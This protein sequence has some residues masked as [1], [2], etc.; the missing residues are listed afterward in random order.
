MCTPIIATYFSSCQQLPGEEYPYVEQP[1]QEYICPVTY[2]IMLQPHLTECCGHH[3]SQEAALRIQEDNK[4]CPICAQN[5]L[6]VILDK[7]VQR[8]VRGLRVFC[9]KVLKGCTWQGE[10]SDYEYHIQS[11]STSDSGNIQQPSE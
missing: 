9:N 6:K 8:K 1:S 11:C 3:I 5:E 2:S 4:G 7:N 10:L